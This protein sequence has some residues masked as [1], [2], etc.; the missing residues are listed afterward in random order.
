MRLSGQ[1]ELVAAAVSFVGNMAKASQYLNS[2]ILRVRLILPW[3]EAFVMNF[4][5]TCSWQPKE[6]IIEPPYQGRALLGLNDLS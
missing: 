2:M 5:V 4:E 1:P 6:I 3:A